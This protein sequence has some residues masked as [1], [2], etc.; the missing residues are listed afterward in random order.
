MP[1]PRHSRHTGPTLPGTRSPGYSGLR[2]WSAV[3]AG[4]LAALLIVFVVLVVVAQAAEGAAGA[5]TIPDDVFRGDPGDVFHAGTIQATAGDECAATLTYTNNSPDPS[6]HPDTDILVGPVTFPDVE[7]GAF[8]SAGLTFTAAGPVDVALR[9]GSDGVSSG[10]YLVELTCNPP[11]T[12]TTTTTVSSTTTTTIPTST[13]STLPP[14]TTTTEPPPI[15]GVDTGGGAC[16]DGGV[17]CP[18]CV[19]GH[20]AAG[21]RDRLRAVIADNWL[22]LAGVVAM[23]GAGLLIGAGWKTPRRKAST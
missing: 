14:V 18:A 4:I 8:V 3:V 10:G 7:H 1:Y 9:I 2:Y 11:T 15:N 22:L 6:D 23:L 21:C 20:T 5:V 13:T 19:S 12:T 17:D 16:A